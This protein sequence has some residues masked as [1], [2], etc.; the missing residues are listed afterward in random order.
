MLFLLIRTLEPIFPAIKSIPIITYVHY[1]VPYLCC[2]QRWLCG[3]SHWGGGGLDS[4]ADGNLPQPPSHCG[5]A[6]EARRRYILQLDVWI[7]LCVWHAFTFNNYAWCLPNVLMWPQ[8]HASSLAA[9]SCVFLC[10]AKG[11]ARDVA[12]SA[13]RANWTH[14]CEAYPVVCTLLSAQPVICTCSS[15]RYIGQGAVCTSHCVCTE[16]F[17]LRKGLFFLPSYLGCAC[18]RYWG[19]CLAP[20]QTF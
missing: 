7:V 20:S 18:L 14:S 13:S 11:S 15:R 6:T 2:M 1:Q 12:P 17:W 5:Q 19:S 8:L 10:T 16:T 4:T 3:C 9:L